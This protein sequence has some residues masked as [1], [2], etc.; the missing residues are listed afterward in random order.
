MP[1]L[2]HLRE[3]VF[4]VVAQ[5]VEAELVV[6][7]VGD[8]AGVGRAAL[9]VVHAVD[10]RADC[11]AKEFVDAAHPFG[12]AAGEI[13][14]DGD[15]VDAF[16]GQRIEIDGERGDE[17]LAFAGA[18]LGDRAFMQH[19]AADELD[20]EMPLAER[21]AR[22]LADGREGRREEIVERLASGQ[23]LA[24]FLGPRAQR[25]VGQR[26]D[27]GLQR[28]DFIDGPVI[29]F[30]PAVVGTSENLLGERPEHS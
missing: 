18:H 4:H 8:V 26:L 17:G 21:A 25:L 9:L 1:A 14:V 19:H 24:E 13:V 5:V 20:V 11:H 12:V 29:A 15:D 28:V 30:Q 3:L 7:A 22:R 23:R 27:L 10:D 16:A 6:R 2:R